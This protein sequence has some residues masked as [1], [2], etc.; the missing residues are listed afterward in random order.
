MMKTSMLMLKRGDLVRVKPSDSD[1]RART[2]GIVLDFDTFRSDVGAAI[3]PIVKV[4][5]SDAPGWVAS[6]R[7]ERIGE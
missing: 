1:P 7:L 2:S 6:D 5:W 4:L 3:I